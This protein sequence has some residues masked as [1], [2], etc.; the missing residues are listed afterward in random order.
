MALP[1]QRRLEIYRARYQWAKTRKFRCMPSV[2]T[3]CCSSNASWQPR[4]V[5]AEEE[6]QC[7][8][9]SSQQQQQQKQQQGEG[10]EEESRALREEDST[11]AN[12]GYNALA[13]L[14][15]L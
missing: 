3:W 4:P 2:V 11:L 7:E 9:S 5:F 10:D 15:L 1:T 13:T 12:R 14:W 6:E 8:R